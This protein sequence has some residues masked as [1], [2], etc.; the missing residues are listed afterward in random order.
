MFAITSFMPYV[1]NYQSSWLTS[2]GSKLITSG[3]TSILKTINLKTKLQYALNNLSMISQFAPISYYGYTM[4]Q[5]LVAQP[6]FSGDFLQYQFNTQVYTAGSTPPQVNSTV[7][8][9]T[10]VAG[11]NGKYQYIISQDFIKSAMNY[12]NSSGLMLVGFSSIYTDLTI[13][14]ASCQLSMLPDVNI[15]TTNATIVLNQSCAVYTNYLA[16]FNVTFNITAN[17]SIEIVKMPPYYNGMYLN[18]SNT[19]YTTPVILNPLPNMNYNIFM[20]HM[21]AF[22]HN[23]FLQYYDNVPLL[24][25]PTPMLKL[26]DSYERGM[27]TFYYNGYVV[28]GEQTAA[29]ESIFR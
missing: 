6:V 23:I 10:T 2:T 8:L 20:N 15:S 29:K 11:I 19:T 3:F 26:V 18:V 24:I 28:V 27:K 17:V 4:N 21:P 14:S 9:P 22:V 13:Y 5:S 25:L 1:E 7:Q 16:N 12:F